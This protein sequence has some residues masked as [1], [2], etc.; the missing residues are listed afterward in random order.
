MPAVSQNQQQLMG[1][2]YAYATGEKRNVP[3]SAKKIARQFMKGPKTT[4]K[5]T[6]KQKEARKKKGIEKLRD[7]ASTK[8]KG[9]PELKN[10]SLILDFEQFMIKKGEY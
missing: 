1:M 6:Q 2:A 3:E 5:L 9:L 8:H 7:F 10:E 4:K